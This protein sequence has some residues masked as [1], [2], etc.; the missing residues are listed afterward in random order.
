LSVRASHVGD[1]IRLVLVLRYRAVRRLEAAGRAR[2]DPYTGATTAFTRGSSTSSDVQ[3]ESSGCWPRVGLRMASRCD[4]LPEVAR[5]V[6]GIELDELET[7]QRADG[8]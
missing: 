1:Q 4:G 2:A 7:G 5:V 6:V 8:G 3:I